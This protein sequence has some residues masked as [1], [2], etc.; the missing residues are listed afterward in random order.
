MR[1]MR[2]KKW[3]GQAATSIPMI[4]SPIFMVACAPPRAGQLTQEVPADGIP[5]NGGEVAPTVFYD[6]GCIE[7]PPAEDPPVYLDGK[8]IGQLWG[9]LAVLEMARMQRVM[10]DPMASR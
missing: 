5:T 3:L 9:A 4:I 7:V 1:F 2:G 10:I 8:L 6:P